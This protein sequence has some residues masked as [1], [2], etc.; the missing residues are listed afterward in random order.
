MHYRC[1]KK[2]KFNSKNFQIISIKE[3]HMESI[4]KWRNSQIDILRQSKI[5]TQKEQKDYYQKIILPEMKNI[6]PN[7]ILLSYTYNDKL[8]G[9]GGLTNISWLNKRCELSF[10]ID[11]KIITNLKKYEY[12][13]INFLKII[14]KISFNELK[15]IKIYTETFSYRN[16]HISVLEKMNFNYDGLLKDHYIIRGKKISSVIHS[17]LKN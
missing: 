4:R 6:K 10:L 1:L 3:V 16:H 13:F 8:I 11:T 7:D 17:C 5:I 14:K 15:F 9:Y 2:K 12:Y